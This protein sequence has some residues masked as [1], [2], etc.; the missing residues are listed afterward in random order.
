MRQVLKILRAIVIVVSFTIAYLIIGGVESGTIQVEK[1][2]YFLI[3][4]GLVTACSLLVMQL[5]DMLIRYKRAQKR[6]T[7]DD[8]Q[9][10]KS[11]DQS[12]YDR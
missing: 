9:S 1:E 3:I 5:I 12:D 10:A 7:W 4:L 8:Y 11:F 6:M 2:T